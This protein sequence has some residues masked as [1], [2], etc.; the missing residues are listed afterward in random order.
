MKKYLLAFGSLAATM[1][2]SIAKPAVAITF[3]S[4]TNSFTV[5]TSSSSADVGE[6]IRVRFN[7]FVNETLVPG[8]TSEGL[9]TVL[10]IVG[11]Q[12]KLQVDIDNTSSTPITSSR[13][14]IL[15]FDINPDPDPNSV[16]STGIFNTVGSGDPPQTVVGNVEYCFKSGGG[17]N[18][19][20][21]GGGGVTF[22]NTGSFSPTLSYA[23]LPSSVTFS[24]FFVRYQDIGGTTLGNSGVGV[25]TV[26]TP[27]LLPGLI[28]IG[29]AALRKRRRN[30]P[31]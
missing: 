13:V 18:C 26:P 6:S 2:L 3:D 15:G 19:S 11:N 27:A 9:F 31:E 16:T 25:G 17:K 24:N 30:E 8:L 22:G 10:P 28:G 12:L 7:G 4:G 23:A 1:S 29:A 14:S 20:G 21:G 5:D